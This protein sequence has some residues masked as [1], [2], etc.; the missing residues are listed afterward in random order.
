MNPDFIGVYP[1]AAPTDF[2]EE[3]IEV[4][5]G[6][7]NANALRYRPEPQ[8]VTDNHINSFD[9]ILAKNHPAKIYERGLDYL[10]A[11]H[12]LYADEYDISLKYQTGSYI[13]LDFQIQRTRPTEGF[14]YWHYENSN[15][16]VRNRIL[17]W[18]L[19]LND[20]K[21]GGET[22]FLYQSKRIKPKQGTLVIWPAA[23]THLHRGN[24][25][26]KE[27]KYIATG[28]FEFNNFVRG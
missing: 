25:P 11:A 17:T 1:N 24:P 16:E 22:E 5:N 20:I 21:E 4:F 14:H 10:W 19:Y 28:W 18:I 7:D 2:C 12:D 15:M 13:N 27:D 8:A 6:Y 23:F 9:L 3:V 26:L